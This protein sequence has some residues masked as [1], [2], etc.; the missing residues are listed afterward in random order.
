M[1]SKLKKYFKTQFLK[2]NGSFVDLPVLD[3]VKISSSTANLYKKKN[4]N[5]LCLFYF[6]NGASHAAVF[7]KSKVFAECIKWNKKPKAKKIKILF[8][9]TKNANALTGQQGFSSLKII[10]KEIS[11]KLNIKDSECYFASTG[12]IGE[13]FPVEKIKKAIPKLIKKNKISSAKN[14]LN[15]AKAIMTTD[16][17]PK[18]SKNSFFLNKK[19]INIVGIAKGSGMIFPNMGTMLGFIFTDLNISNQLLKL[20]LKNNLDR[21]FNAISVDGDTSTNDMVLLFSTQ[22]VKNKKITSSKTKEFKLFQSKLNQVM[23]SLAKQITIDGEGAGKFVEI[24]VRGAQNDK[25]AKQ[26]AFSVANSQLFK[27]AVAG[28]D[29]NWGRILMAIGKSNSS[30]NINKID[31]K[32]GDQLIFKYGN[33]SKNY[34]EKQSLKYMK[35]TKIKIF[36]DLNLGKSEF[37]AYTCDLTHKYISINADYRN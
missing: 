1:N 30:I 8:I 13:K 19:K 26:I 28:E 16:T 9:N 14:W 6:M 17:I 23:L 15:A 31:L 24:D 2:N 35:E 4:R 29:P 25:D 20:A 12:V 36:I 11:K 5:D 33:I 22:R 18:L 32:L 27:T 10:R 21:T 37:K 3:G 7:T 34:K